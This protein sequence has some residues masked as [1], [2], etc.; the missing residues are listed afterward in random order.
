MEIFEHK[1]KEALRYLGY[2]QKD[3][4]EEITSSV[5]SLMNELENFVSPK[6]TY[7]IVDISIDEQNKSID[8]GL[9][10]VVS[11]SLSRNLKD[12]KKAA[13][14]A[15]TLGTNADLIIR[16]Y[17]KSSITKSVMINACASSLIEECCDNYQKE[18]ESKI[19]GYFRPRFSPG[20]GDFNLEHQKDIVALLDTKKNIG[21]ALSDTL[22]LLPEKSVTAVIG[23]SEKF[24]HCPISGCEACGKVDCEYRR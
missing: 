15:A 10:N 18:I 4:D 1:I 16:R 22:I 19:D 8:F 5:Q 11:K 2:K 20:Y 3:V 9:F 12:C 17:A 23:I 14:F 24:E 6:Y 7:K 21:L 13:V